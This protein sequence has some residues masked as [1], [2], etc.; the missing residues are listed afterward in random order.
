MKSEEGVYVEVSGRT[1]A[2]RGISVEYDDEK[3]GREVEEEG[4]GWRG[5][6]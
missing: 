4:V 1:Q 3:G 5:G 2:P 6:S